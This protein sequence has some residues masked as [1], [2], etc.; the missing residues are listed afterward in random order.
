LLVLW[1]REPRLVCGW[2]Q[3]ATKHSHV[4]YSPKEVCC[5]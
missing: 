1:D 4:D 3:C 5:S 2:Q